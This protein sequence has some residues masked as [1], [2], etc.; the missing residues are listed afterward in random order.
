MTNEILLPLSPNSEL[1][2][3]IRLRRRETCA[4][5]RAVARLA[6]DDIEIEVPLAAAAEIEQALT[7]LRFGPG[8]R[9]MSM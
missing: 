2:A 3:V 4:A 5:R 1:D 7:A 9:V 8:M 6:R